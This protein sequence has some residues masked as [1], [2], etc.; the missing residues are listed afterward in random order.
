[1][2]VYL[3]AWPECAVDTDQTNVLLS[4]ELYLPQSSY[5]VAGQEQMLARPDFS[6]ST[7]DDGCSMPKSD[8]TPQR[9]PFSYRLQ[10]PLDNVANCGDLLC[11]PDS[12]RAIKR[13]ILKH[14]VPLRLHEENVICSRQVQPRGVS[15]H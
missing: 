6:S 1:M 3:R 14:G 7:A 11:L 4:L 15:D 9:E 13:L 12:V 2:L 8:L 10:G 5:C